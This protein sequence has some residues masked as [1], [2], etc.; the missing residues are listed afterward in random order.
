MQ[1]TKSFKEWEYEIDRA[2]REIFRKYVEM[3]DESHPFLVDDY[4][5]ELA[6]EMRRID[7]FYE[8][9]IEKEADELK[10]KRDRGLIHI[11]P[12]PFRLEGLDEV[13]PLI[14]GLIS[15]KVEE[16]EEPEEK[17]KLLK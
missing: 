6:K 3:E 15:G 10:V 9:L 5:M 13:I 7:T 11:E 17:Q 12:E 16:L 14:H 4:R 8:P 2:K 1:R